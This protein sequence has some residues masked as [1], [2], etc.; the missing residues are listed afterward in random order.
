MRKEYKWKEFSI[1]FNART[2][3]HLSRRIYKP[4]KRSYSYVEVSNWAN[5]PAS[6]D[7]WVRLVGYNES[8]VFSG[9]SLIK[10]AEELKKIKRGAR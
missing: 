9:N 2:H 1:F 7:L 6:E 3:E 10:L 5:I 4:Q 8:V